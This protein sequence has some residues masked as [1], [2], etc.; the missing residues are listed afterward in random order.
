MT[1]VNTPAQADLIRSL[2]AQLGYD[3]DEYDNKCDKWEE[4]EK[5]R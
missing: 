4:W 3:P 2:C 5:W 1:D